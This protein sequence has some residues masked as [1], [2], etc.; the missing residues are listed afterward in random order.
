MLKNLPGNSF[1]PTLLCLIALLATATVTPA[2]EGKHGHSS[3]TGAKAPLLDGLIDLGFA[4]TT[5]SQAARDYF[6]QGLVLTYGFD[7]ADAEVSYLEAAR[8]DPEAAMA[9]WGAALVLGPNINAPMNAADAPRAYERAQKAL[10]LA[11]KAS[12]KERALAEALAT[13]YAPE[14]PADRSALDEAFAAAMRQVYQRYPD[15]PNIAVLFAEALMD[16][17]P[18]NYWT[19]DDRAQPWTPEIEAVLEKVI[20]E[21]PRH[22]HGH[23]LYI[24]LLENSP[25]PEATVKSADII[26]HLV[27]AAGHLVHMAGH[28]YY[29]AGLYHDCSV[30]N[31]D[32]IGVDRKLKA[33]FAT[34]GLYQLAYM[35]HN[36]HFLLASYMMEGRSRDAV[37][38]ARNLSAGVDAQQMRHPALVSLQHFYLTPYYALLRFG[39]W[40]EILAEPAPPADLPYPQAM[41]HYARGMALTRQ[42]NPEGAEAELTQLQALAAEPALAEMKVW[43]LNKVTDLLAVASEVLSGEIAAA[44]GG[45]EAALGHFERAVARQD[46]LLFDEPPTW[47]FPVRQALGALLLDLGRWQEAETVFRQD[48]RKNAENPWSL[49]GLAEALKAQGQDELGADAERRFRRAWARADVELRRPVF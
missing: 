12:E 49:F 41:W 13:R 42:G 1:L 15:D 6:N 2:M 29:A 30:V 33:A 21:H 27:P 38:A 19:E 14:A 16:L 31:E 47:Y 11:A 24:H 10:A 22:P 20:A 37:A 44:R 28:A 5:D 9:W 26:R 23:H 36:L 46:K 4:L 17:H 43:D 34:E 25:K 39:H 40:D 32:A 7:H 18:W 35:P 48:L 8:H 45:K 3:L